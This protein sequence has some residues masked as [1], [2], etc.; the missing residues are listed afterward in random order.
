MKQLIFTAVLAIFF[1]VGLFAQYQFPGRGYQNYGRP[2]NGYYVQPRHFQQPYNYRYG[3]SRRYT[4]GSILRRVQSRPIVAVSHQVYRS[5]P[6]KSWGITLVV[7]GIL[8]G[9]ST[10]AYHFN[11][12]FGNPCGC[13]PRNYYAR[14]YIISGYSLSAASII[15]G[16]IMIW[17]SNHPGGTV[18]TYHRTRYGGRLDSNGTWISRDPR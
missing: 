11:Y 1:S 18:R 6:L 12:E 8:G 16:S 9:I 5:D 4:G 17:K 14:Y 15:A 10:G 2:Q 3:N 7:F 13:S